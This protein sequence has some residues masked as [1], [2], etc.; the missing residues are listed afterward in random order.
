MMPSENEGLALVTYESMSMQTPIF[1]TNVGAQDEL[2]QPEFLVENRKPM[3]KKFADAIWPYLVNS[4]KRQ[5]TGV[6]MRNYILKHHRH[7][8]TYLQFQALYQKLL[9]Q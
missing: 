8:Q 4:E 5:Q 7:E 1:F 9:E 2:L 6:E 3:A